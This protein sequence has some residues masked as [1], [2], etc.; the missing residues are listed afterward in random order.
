MSST[1]PVQYYVTHH[2]QGQIYIFD[3]DFNYISNKSSFASVNYMISIGTNFYITGDQNVWKTDEQLNVLIQYNDLT[4]SYH[5]IYYNSTNSLIYIPSVVLQV[6]H[7]FNLD[8]TLNNNISIVNNFPWSITGFNNELFVGT[9]NGKILI[10]SNQQIIQEF[11][12]CN[13]NG[14]IVFSILFDQFYNM[15]SSCSNNQLYLYNTTGTFLNKN[16]STVSNPEFIGFDS[17]S[18]LVV[19]MDSQISLYN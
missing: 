16:I 6:I 19:V 12:A 9:N 17:K 13:G 18:R 15:A 5:G 14:V 3:E 7:L 8:L 11:N 2:V 1:I 4:A 10:I